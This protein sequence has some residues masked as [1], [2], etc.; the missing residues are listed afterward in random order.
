MNYRAILPMI[1]SVL[2]AN[3]AIAQ[4]HGHL[5]VGATG[6][7]QDAPLIF[8]NGGDFATSTEYVK[9]LTLATNGTYAGFYQGNISLTALAATPD[10]GGLVPNA[11]ALGSWIFVQLVS[12]EGPAGGS[13]A[14]WDSGATTPTIDL[15]TGTTG[16][17]SW[18][19]SESDGA[20]GTDPY[21]HIH[22]RRFTATIPG[23][24]TV[25]FRA[26]DLSTNG[27]GG[28]PI[29]KPSDVLMVY[30]QAGVNIKKI[31]PDVDHIHIQFSAP[32]GNAWTV[33]ASD[34]M[35]PD[36]AWT[37]IAAP[38]AGDDRFHEVTDE[39]SVETQRFYRAKAVGP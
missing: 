2:F 28:G 31:E 34:S 13:F 18:R 36:A 6:T 1:G 37:E 21:G 32:V 35:A 5:N 20:P 15:M 26:I 23:I 29:H 30:F 4:D 9:T 38:I 25:G 11:P 39:H 17:N 8:D 19:L 10:F 7:T 12:V 14:F 24:Y 33:E 27:T 16:T 3:L 22:G